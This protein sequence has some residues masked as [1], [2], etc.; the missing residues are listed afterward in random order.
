MTGRYTGICEYGRK[1]DWHVKFINY[2]SFP[3]KSYLHIWKP[4]GI[5]SDS[6]QFGTRASDPIPTVYLDADLTEE[7]QA[8]VSTVERDPDEAARIAFQEFKRL[9]I[10]S[11]GFLPPLIEHRWS[12][13]RRDSF[14]RIA[15]EGG[16]KV[17]V[18]PKRRHANDSPAIHKSIAKWAARLPR[19]CGVFVAND[20]TGAFFLSIC[21]LE[22]IKIPEELAVISV[23]G[24]ETITENTFP[25]LSSVVSADSAGGRLAAELLDNLMSGTVTEPVHLCFGELG[26]LRKDSTKRFYKRNRDIDAAIDLIRREARKGLKAR[27]VLCV[28]N[29]SRRSAEMRF[30][31]QTGKSIL[32]AIYDE[33][34]KHAKNMLKA[35]TQPIS[36][37]ARG[38]GFN[39]IPTLYRLFERETGMTM[40]EWREQAKDVDAAAHARLPRQLR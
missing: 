15:A 4:Q 39:S 28:M 9:G 32:T 14:L 27:D 7:E 5:I 31:A 1:H 24:D 29:G 26:L 25:T 37:I 12:D 23:D 6:S 19:P 10:S 8:A 40:G 3:L 18:Y 36:Q 2:G 35:T 22:G 33:R 11:L 17:N 34:L 20:S 16:I 38:C 30:K 21:A 13:R